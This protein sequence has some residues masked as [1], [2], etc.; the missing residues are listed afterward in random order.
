MT[1]LDSRASISIFQL[2]FYPPALAAAI[3]LCI[4]HGF[5]RSSGY[6]FL[7]TV[8][9]FRIAGGAT[10]LATYSTPST[11]LFIASA[12]LGSF[13]LSALLLASLGF[14][15]RT[16][17]STTYSRSG[18]PAIPSMA[19][20]LV[21]LLTTVGLIISVVGDADITVDSATRTLEVPVETK[22]GVI[23]LVVA[24]LAVLLIAARSVQL[25]AHV[26]HA[27]RPLIWAVLVCLPFLLIRLI[28]SILIVF[29]DDSN[30]SLIF[31]STVVLWTLSTIEECFT[32][33]IY[34]LVGFKVPKLAAAEPAGPSL[35]AQDG[36]SAPGYTASGPTTTQNNN[37]GRKSGG[38]IRWR[39][40]IILTIIGTISDLFQNRKAGGR[41]SE[42]HHEMH[43]M[44]QQQQQ[45][46]QS[47]SM[48]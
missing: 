31:P 26:A 22:V 44:Q 32:V 8:S 37:T 47:T 45:Q 48:A 24:W 19:F 21:Q 40:S 35:M 41:A 25:I 30:F 9:L 6:L 17:D 34:L 33:T 27:E 20:R 36:K 7:L 5:G 3:F 23:I 11:G 42:P 29:L 38:G 18:K 39:G 2:V 16:S 12:I 10:Q 1:Q 15:S 43:G 4:K 46:Q 13:G 14:L 28:Y